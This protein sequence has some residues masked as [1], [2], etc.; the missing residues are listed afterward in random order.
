MELTKELP[1][2]LVP[3]HSKPCNKRFIFPETLLTWYGTT[4]EFNDVRWKKALQSD[5]PGKAKFQYVYSCSSIS[6]FDVLGD[7]DNR[8]A[9]R[10]AI[11]SRYTYFVGPDICS[12]NDH[13]AL[14]E[15]RDF[16]IMNEKREMQKASTYNIQT[17]SYKLVNG[18]VMIIP[19]IEGVD[20]RRTNLGKGLFCGLIMKHCVCGSCIERSHFIAEI[21]GIVH[22]LRINHPVEGALLRDFWQW[23]LCMERLVQRLTGDYF[24]PQFI[25]GG[26]YITRD[27]LSPTNSESGHTRS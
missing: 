1:E 3:F 5:K 17:R 26:Q 27:A 9:L 14:F 7:M 22:L 21:V 24:I 18:E 13:Y 11:F 12:T 8:K 6:V 19:Y 10:A 16:L 2:F 23:T 25:T 4:P 15:S 20:N